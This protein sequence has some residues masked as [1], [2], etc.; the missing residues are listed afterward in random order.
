MLTPQKID[1]NSLYLTDQLNSL[2]VEVVQKCVVGD[3]RRRLSDVV[4]AAM[5]RSEV[6]IVTGGLGPTED[7]VTRDAVALALGRGMYFDQHVCDAIAER[8]RRFNRKMA[9][10]NKR[11]AYIIDGAEVLPNPRGTAPGQWIEAGEAIVMLLPG[12]PKELIGL[13][14]TEAMPRLQAKLPPQVIRTRF[15]RV[16]GMTESEVDSTVAPI[17]TRYANPMCTILAAS[18]DI[19]LHLRARCGTSDEAEALLVEVGVQ[20]EAAL[21]DRLY[22]CCGE[23]LED[24]V[25]GIL[26]ARSQT[27]SVAESCTGGLLAKRFTEVAGSS[28]YF[29][30]GFVTY[31]DDTKAKLLGIDRDLIEREGAVSDVVARLMAESARKK[32]GTDYAVSI[33]GIAGP[34]GGSEEL[35]VGSVFIG[36]ATPGDTQVKEIRLPGDR[37]WIRTLA[38]NVALDMLRIH[39]LRPTIG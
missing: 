17:Y 8:F 24:C 38:T 14:E 16:A 28:R 21:G 11:Q 9:E 23:S 34:D 37:N 5:T 18:G 3:D 1:T 33:T 25:G 2:G 12:P 29:A 36:L 10:I 30:G 4:R 35:P 19:Q 32:L 22:T 13:W 20:I 39:L 7:D 31:T 15:Y 6:I 27:V 26:S